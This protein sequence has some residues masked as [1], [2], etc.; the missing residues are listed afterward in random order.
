[1]AESDRY[2]DNPFGMKFNRQRAAEYREQ[3]FWGDATLLDYWRTS[4]SRHPEKA[5]VIDSH[6]ESLTFSQADE[7]AAKI[8]RFLLETGVC[9]GD[10]VSFQLPGWVEFLP[11]YVA[12]LKVGAVVNPIPPNLRFEDVRYI[13]AL[14][15][16]KV[17]FTPC[18]YR[19]YNYENMVGRL[20]RQLPDLLS[21]IVVQKGRVSPT[22]QSLSGILDTHAPLSAA[23]VSVIQ[24]SSV[25]ADSLAALLFTSGSEGRPKGVMLTHN[26]IIF[27]ENSFAAY[28]NINQ[29]DVMLM[30]AP[31]THATGFHHGVTMPFMVGATTVLQDLFNPKV[32][33][34]LVEQHGCTVSM[35]SAPFLYDMLCTLRCNSYDLSTLR[36]FLCGGSPVNPAIMEEAMHYDLNT[37]NVYGSTESVP[38]AGVLVHHSPEKKFFTAGLPMPGIEVKVIDQQGRTVLIGQEGQEASRGPQVFM[39]YFK[40][41]EL[42]D[43]SID[44]Q[45]WYHSGD[46]CVMDEDGFIRITGRIKDIIIRGG[47]NISSLEVENFLLRH[48]NI[49]EAAV[50]GMPDPRL[51]ERACAYVV[52]EDKNA[53]LCFSDMVDFLLNQDIAK[54]KFPERLEIVDKLPKT[55][56]GKVKKMQLRKEIAKKLS[57]ECKAS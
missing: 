51:T 18:L 52:L 43:A 31:V 15:K 26:N 2:G 50:V 38:H 47:E 28:F 4:V 44:E 12:C 3:G 6:A 33:L 49:K 55:A 1:M 48:P 7:A 41:P 27:S 45:G 35:A 39:G 56:S 16:T 13:T 20:C 46:L 19:K 40:D 8:A 10:V 11:V 32:T 57:R 42:S 9:P 22:C 30:P 37:C 54:H 23:E 14:C 25:H 21:A 36:F 24:E 5:A 53:G 29:F 34:Q 17:L